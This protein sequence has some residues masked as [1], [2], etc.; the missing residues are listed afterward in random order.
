MSEAQSADLVRLLRD[1]IVWSE[2]AEAHVAGHS[3]ATFV[4][5]AKTA[6]AVCWCITCVGEAAGAILR[7]KPEFSGE[8]DLVQAYSMRNRI[9]HGYFAVDLGIV[10]NV[11]KTY[12]PELKSAARRIMRTMRPGA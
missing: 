2:R 6:D 9:T 7:R 8:L 3:E 10:W 1:M 4:A 12:L 5:D 11:S